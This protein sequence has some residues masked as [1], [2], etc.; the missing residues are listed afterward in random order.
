LRTAWLHCS[1]AWRVRRGIN[2]AAYA[3]QLQR[4][5]NPVCASRSCAVVRPRLH[6]YQLDHASSVEDP[7]KAFQPHDTA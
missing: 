2:A 6:R 5:F 7:V 3:Q 4:P 1:A